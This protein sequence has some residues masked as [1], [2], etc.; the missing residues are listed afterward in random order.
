M[1]LYARHISN[2]ARQR[3]AATQ[4]KNTSKGSGMKDNENRETKTHCQ[5]E[6][7]GSMVGTDRLNVR[8]QDGEGGGGIALRCCCSLGS[9]N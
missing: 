3:T 9:V 7:R 1:L 5:S 4:K 8:E 6:A 2:F